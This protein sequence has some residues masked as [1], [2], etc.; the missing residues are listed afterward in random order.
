M[1]SIRECLD[2]EPGI[3]KKAYPWHPHN[4]QNVG[5]EGFEGCW[6]SR[7]SEKETPGSRAYRQ[8]G[9]VE[10]GSKLRMSRKEWLQA[11]Q[12]RWPN[13]ANLERLKT[14]GGLSED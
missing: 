12:D 14:G 9:Q 1:R 8:M 4:L 10:L 3:W 7:F 5:Y 6:G 13:E 11:E 2:H